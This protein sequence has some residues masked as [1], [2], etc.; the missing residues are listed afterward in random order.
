MVTL[1]AKAI[2]IAHSGSLRRS[3]EFVPSR[4]RFSDS[5]FR[6]HLLVVPKRTQ[7]LA[8]WHSDDIAADR[9]IGLQAGG[10]IP[11]VPF[12]I[13]V[14][15]VVKRDSPIAPRHLWRPD[16]PALEHIRRHTRGE[17]GGHLF[18]VA[19]PIGPVDRHAGAGVLFLKARD[20]GLFE[21]GLDRITPVDHRQR[22]FDPVSLR[23]NRLYAEQCDAGGGA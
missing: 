11:P 9:D 19:A 4:W 15:E 13:G 10:E 1:Y 22:I 7:I 8:I 17:S 20:D 6:Q 3:Q 18:V 21:G 2:S 16:S 23:R 5:A 12:F 14:D